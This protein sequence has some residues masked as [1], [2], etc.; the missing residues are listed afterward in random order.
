M[1]TTFMARFAETPPSILS[2]T[3][4]KGKKQK[5]KNAEWQRKRWSWP[6]ETC[7]PRGKS[8]NARA[9]AR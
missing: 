4:L 7:R 6:S 8:P 2:N 1:E 5:R 3:T 9:L